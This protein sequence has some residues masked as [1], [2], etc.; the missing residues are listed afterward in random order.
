MKNFYQD[1]L[2]KMT[3]QLREQESDRVTLETELKKYEH[4]SQKYKDLRTA[5]KAKEKHIDHL[6]NRQAEI[7]S[8]TSIA[9]RNE[10]VIENLKGEILQMKQQKIALQKQLAQ[11]RKAHEKSLKLLKK[12]ALHHEKDAN[13]AKQDLA[14][15]LAQKKRV[16]DI[17]KSHAGEVSQLRAKYQESEKKLRMQTLKRGVME[18]AG[19]DPVLVGRKVKN[20]QKSSRSRI[21]SPPSAQDRRTY[22]SSDIH[23]MRSFLDDKV[24]EISRKEATADKLAVEWEDHLELTTRRDQIVSA[25]KQKKDSQLS[26]ELEALDF[27]IQ[28][29]ESRIR[30]LASRLSA[31]PRTAGNGDTSHFL[32][33]TMIDDRKFKEITSEFSALAA[34]QMASKVLFGMVVKERRRVAKLARTASSLDQKVLDA[35]KLASSK[36]AALRSHMEESKN[37]RVSMAQ[38]HQ[39]KIL[40]LMSLLH[41]DQEDQ[42]RVDG[43]ISPDR[44]DSVILSL[45]NER[46]DT[47]EKQLEEMQMEKETREKYQQRESET[48]QELI[49]LTEDYGQMLEQSKYLRHSLA[50]VRDKIAAPKTDLGFPDSKERADILKIIDAATKRGASSTQAKIK[51][52][53][54]STMSIN[55]RTNKPVRST[56][57]ETESEEEDEPEWAGNIMNDLAII[58]AGDVP[59][60]LR[61]TTNQRP[62]I[63]STGNIYDRL[64]NLD[65]YTNSQKNTHD[66][67][68]DDV[69]S[70]GS[71]RSSRSTVRK[72]RA[73]LMR[74]QPSP[75]NNNNRSPVRS[76]SNARSRSNTP[77]RKRTYNTPTPFRHTAT[78][79][80]PGGGDS[81]KS[82]MSRSRLT[83]RIA[84]ILKDGSGGGSTGTGP[85]KELNI[86]NSTSYSYSSRDDSFNTGNEDKRF[87]KAYTKKDVFERLQKKM[88]NSYTLA[89]KAV[90]EDEERN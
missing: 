14:K 68:S 60:S 57:Y 52:N 90:I 79:S 62:P 56:F 74:I 63:R 89:Q 85:P 61:K 84:E 77:S 44:H 54:K 21:H 88:T 10:S 1:K 71:T 3:M 42:Y 13:K 17:A 76:H 2:R 38:S 75:T 55:R 26:D 20:N 4:D 43:K 27:Q 9:S 73:S 36:E 40:S 72:D 31:R 34:A 32:Q 80:T 16:Q 70:V 24:A 82:A 69:N 23:Q 11:E 64:S 35:E 49:K 33:D 50:K 6:R 59:P 67:R 37:E 19:I 87:I 22:T 29:K 48:V 83:D 41:Q 8:L 12:K 46:I 7:E 25:S 18:R 81:V 58:A 39:E 5:L 15:T 30:Q 45:A 51:T 28:Y 65:N 86:P 53:K 66:R 78:P 47:L